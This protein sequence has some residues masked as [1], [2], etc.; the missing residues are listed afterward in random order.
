[1]RHPGIDQGFTPTNLTNDERILSKYRLDAGYILAV[2]NGRPHKNLGVLLKIA[3]QIDRR[4]L[5][6]GVPS[7]NEVYWKSRFPTTKASWIPF[8][9]EEELPS[10]LR[11]AFCLAQPS[12]AEGYAYPPLEAMACD[13]PAVVSD[14]PVLRETTGCNALEADPGKPEAWIEAFRTLENPA[15][16]RAQVDK[17]RSWVEP[18]RGTK[19]WQGHVS[20]IKE[21]LEERS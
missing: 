16:Y 10:I 15:I 5:F 4:L 17:G 11:G 9:E 18:L 8:V 14:I 1:M 21:L 13:V 20:D 6:V 19:G 12:T 3:P 2:G 7:A